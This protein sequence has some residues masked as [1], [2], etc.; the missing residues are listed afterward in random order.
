ME[1]LNHA[2]FLMINA[3]EQSPAALIRLAEFL[4]EWVIYGI[5]FL[6]IYIWVKGSHQSR[7]DVL[8]AVV[9]VVITLGLGQIINILWPH[10]RPFMIGLGHTFLAH[11]PEASFPSDHAIVF[12]T[13]GLS[14]VL[15]SMRKWGLA[16]LLTGCTVSWARVYLGV[17]FP[18]DIVGGFLVA[19]P[20]IG[21]AR[22]ILH[23]HKLGQDFITRL[24]NLY[25][26][27]TVKMYKV[28]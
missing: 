10:P 27:P 5:P 26:R 8:T 11:K 13:L 9:S 16:V 19:I 7:F 6:L 22:A 2:W 12:F 21:L 23:W 18:F 28:N 1:A 4:A 14:F 25:Q 20:G 24:E 15:T 17:H 3:N